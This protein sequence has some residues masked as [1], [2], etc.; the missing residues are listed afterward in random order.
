[1]Y[2]VLDLNL[3]LKNGFIETDVCSKPTDSH[4]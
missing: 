2:Y 4:L 1:M 3:H